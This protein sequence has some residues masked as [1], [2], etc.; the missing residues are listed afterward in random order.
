MPP[1]LKRVSGTEVIGTFHRFGFEVHSRR[2]SH[3]KLVRVTEHGER[4]ILTIPDHKELDKGTL[5]SIIR[6]AS[7]FIAESELREFFYSE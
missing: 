4:Q 7:K 3:V 1:K 2:G 6:Q 5:R